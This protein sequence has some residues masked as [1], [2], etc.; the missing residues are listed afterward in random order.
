M[1]LCESVPVWQ[2]EKL[3]PYSCKKGCY[4]NVDLMSRLRCCVLKMELS[5]EVKLS[6]VKLCFASYVFQLNGV[7]HLITIDCD[8]VVCCI[9]TSYVLF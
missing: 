8:Q 9:N 2:L 3:Q 1:S 7:N 6:L 5:G 4:G